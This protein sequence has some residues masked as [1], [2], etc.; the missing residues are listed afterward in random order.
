MRPLI[1]LTLCIFAVASTSGHAL[2]DPGRAA[3]DDRADLPDVRPGVSDA[4][5]AAD[6]GGELGFA[7][8]S[9]DVG[10]PSSRTTDSGPD[11]TSGRDAADDATAAKADR[12]KQWLNEIWAPLP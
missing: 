1:R 7:R 12:Q 10:G 5:R 4:T 11:A 3:G 2:A 8:T 9:Q 6:A